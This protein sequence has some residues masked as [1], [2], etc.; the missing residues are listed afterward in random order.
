MGYDSDANESNHNYAKALLLG[1]QEK[2]SGYL[3][4]YVSQ[5]YGVEQ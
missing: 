1:E 4:C 3:R 2:L 5:R